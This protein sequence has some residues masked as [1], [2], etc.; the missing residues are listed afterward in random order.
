VVALGLLTVCLTVT[1]RTYL[2]GSRAELAQERRLAALGACQ[3][4]IERLHAAGAGAVALGERSFAVVKQAP[5]QG[6]LTISPGPV[7]GTRRVAARARWE[8]DDSAP[9]GEV[10]LVAI[11]GTGDGG[12]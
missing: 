7:A 4:Q 3:E 8:G 2:Q 12:G 5:I 10:A 9:A 6:T 11:L 1:L